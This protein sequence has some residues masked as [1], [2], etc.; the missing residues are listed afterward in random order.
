MADT[1]LTAAENFKY[2]IRRDTSGAAAW[3]RDN[4]RGKRWFRWGS[5][6][7]G[8]LLVVSLVGWTVLTNGLPDARALLQYEPPLPSVV[9]G[10]DG[11]IVH[12]YAR[13]RRV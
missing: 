4:W 8:A 7:L 11:E 1:D 12:T 5:S 6:A 3:F 9:R 13:E 2:R 10:A